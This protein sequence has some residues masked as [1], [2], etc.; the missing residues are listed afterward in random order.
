MTIKDLEKFREEN[1]LGE[2]DG[3]KPLTR[4]EKA[5]IDDNLLKHK[6]MLRL[7]DISM[8]V[9]FNLKKDYIHNRFIHSMQVSKICNIMTELI[10]DTLGF[11]IDPRG[12][13]EYVGLIH[14][15]GHTSLGHKMEQELKR[16]F[17]VFGIDYDGNANNYV[18]LDRTKLLDIFTEEN[19]SYILASL[20]KHFNDLYPSQKK[21]KENVFINIL[22]DEQLLK[23]NGYEMYLSQTLGCMVMDIADE[24]AYLIS[25]LMDAMNILSKE[26]MKKAIEKYCSIEVQET[27]IPAL[28]ASKSEF[29][30]AL[31]SYTL[32]FASNFRLENGKLIPSSKKIEDIRKAFRKINVNLVI[33]SEKMEKLQKENEVIIRRTISYFTN[34]EYKLS[35]IPSSF[36][37]KKLKNASSEEERLELIRDMLGGLTDKGLMKIYK[38]IKKEH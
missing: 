22:K 34:K 37:K 19:R 25:D 11:N 16:A 21:E 13:F 33:K 29:R 4:L 23:E 20:A 6:T 32:M 27:L 9:A 38:K 3:I 36:Y 7:N 26:E 18:A 10:S 35:D 31:N 12:V 15:V 28:G 24:I 5:I 17:K 14:D 2:M 30:A 8:A 1:L